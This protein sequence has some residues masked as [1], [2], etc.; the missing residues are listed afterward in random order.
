MHKGFS[1]LLLVLALV[2]GM[3]S[4][5]LVWA[6]DGTVPPPEDVTEEEP[7]EPAPIDLAPILD[8]ANAEINAMSVSDQVKTRLRTMVAERLQEAVNRGF[9]LE[10]IQ[11]LAPQMTTLVAQCNLEA[12]LP[13]V[14]ACFQLMIKGMRNGS[15]ADVGAMIAAKLAAGADLKTA[16]K[17][18]R[19]ELKIKT[20]KDQGQKKDKGAKEKKEKGPKG[21]K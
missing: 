10:Q 12:D 6:Q 20:P 19:F 18:T 4:F 3:T 17:Q 7:V 16:L 13:H 5:Q 14:N 2:L 21:E 11:G 9:T 1:L 15:T 8:T